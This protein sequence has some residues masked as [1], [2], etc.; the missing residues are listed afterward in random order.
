V[1]PRL[2]ILVGGLI[3]VDR[4]YD[5]FDPVHAPARTEQVDHSNRSTMITAPDP[6]QGEATGWERP[7]PAGH[8]RVAR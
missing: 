7:K 4:S 2:I 6:D 3:T 1:D 5:A 8:Y